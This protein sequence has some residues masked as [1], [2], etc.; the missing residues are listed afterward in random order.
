MDIIDV[1]MLFV[2]SIVFGIMLWIL[3]EELNRLF[4]VIFP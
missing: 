3:I 4:G 2:S 1:V